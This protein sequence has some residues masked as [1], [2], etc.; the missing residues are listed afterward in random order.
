MKRCLILLCLLLLIFSTNAQ[1]GYSTGNWYAYQGQSTI[2][3]TYKSVWNDFNGWQNVR[4]C[5]QLNWY[6]EWHAGY[7]YY[8][9]WDSFHGQYRWKRQ[10]KEGN[11]WYC[12][13]SDWY[14]C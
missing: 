9:Q 7:V 12:T 3:T 14:V 2:E 4:Y 5:R 13:W 1:S 10:W 6:Q 11:Y 8:W